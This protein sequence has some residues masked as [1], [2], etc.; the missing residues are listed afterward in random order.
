MPSNETPADQTAPKAKPAKKQLAEQIVELAH[1]IEED[2]APAAEAVAATPAPASDAPIKIAEPEPSTFDKNQAFIR[3]IIEARQAAQAEAE[4]APPAQA[5]MTERQLSQTEL[6]IKRGKE[7]Q[8]HFA[9]IDASRPPRP[10]DPTAGTSTP[11]HRPADFVPN[12]NSGNV[13]ATTLKSA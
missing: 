6:E 13:R 10:V 4:Q 12:M 2:Q 11:V 3:K 1:E 5:G 7:R 9:A 8:A